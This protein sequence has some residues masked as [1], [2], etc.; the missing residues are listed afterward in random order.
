MEGFDYESSDGGIEI[1]DDFTGYEN[2]KNAAASSSTITSAGP[3]ALKNLDTEVGSCLARNLS[4]DRRYRW[5]DSISATIALC[6]AEGTS[7]SSAAGFVGTSKTDV[8][9]GQK[10]EERRDPARLYETF[11]AFRMGLATEK[12]DGKG[13]GYHVVSV[14]VLSALPGGLS[15][16]DSNPDTPASQPLSRRCL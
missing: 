4:L 16:S 7:K 3:S 5:P 14:S 9:L 2:S 12:D 8:A 6:I 13:V 10:E 11:R 15:H 1:L